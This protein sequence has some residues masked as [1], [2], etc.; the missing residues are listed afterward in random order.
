[1]GE[2]YLDRRNGAVQWSAAI[3]EAERS[4]GTA[5]PE[6]HQDSMDGFGKGNASTFYGNRFSPGLRSVGGG[7]N[8]LGRGVFRLVRFLGR[9]GVGSLVL[10]NVQ[11]V[12]QFLLPKNEGL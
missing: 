2:Q 5:V 4:A 8:L 3:H 11:R 12:L 7:V 1:M 6:K 9:Q 10:G